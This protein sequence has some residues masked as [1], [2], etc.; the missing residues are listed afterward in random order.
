LGLSKVPFSNAL[1]STILQFTFNIKEEKKKKKPVN[2]NQGWEP[3]HKKYKENEN[4]S[5]HNPKKNKSKQST[6]IK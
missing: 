3:I 5:T 4:T 1:L 6:K 2:K